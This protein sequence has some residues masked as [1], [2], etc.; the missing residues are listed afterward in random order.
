MSIVFNPL[1]GNFETKEPGPKGDTG[2]VVSAA[3]DGTAA[4]P[5]ISFASD[6]NTGIYKYANDAIGFATNGGGRVFIDSGGKIGSANPSVPLTVIGPASDDED[7]VN[8]I[9][10]SNVGTN[11]NGGHKQDEGVAIGFRLKR[12]GTTVGATSNTAFIKAVAEADLVNS[13]PTALTFGVRRF[14]DDPVEHV[15]IES[16]GKTHFKNNIGVGVAPGLQAIRVQQS[17]VTGAPSRSSALYLENNGNCEI[18]LVGNPNNDCQIRFGTD[19]NS[20]KGALEYQ[21]DNDAFVAYTGGSEK[22]RI[23]SNGLATFAG[24]ALIGSGTA[25]ASKVRIDPTGYVNIQSNASAGEALRIYDNSSTQKITLK[26]NGTAQFAGSIDTSGNV[27]IGADL[28]MANGVLA[29]SHVSDSNIDHIW[30]DE[31]TNTFI[32]NSDTTRKDTAGTGNIKA[33]NITASGNLDLTDSTI[34]LYSQTTNAASKTFQLFSDIGGTKTEKA[35]ILA[36]GSAQFSGDIETTTAATG[37]ILNSPNGTRYRLT[38]ANDGT[39]STTAV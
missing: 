27:V 37:V 8:P 6:T 22:F 29:I 14:G 15:R 16:T 26:S 34:D 35:A 20:F 19:S 25:G 18:Q 32:F 2:T 21:L 13:Y 30:H 36:D 38:V 28:K 4:A 17:A 23:G 1:S 10:L 31:N 5:A 7:L 33:A 3:G 9:L 11:T 39:L 24:Q 12:N